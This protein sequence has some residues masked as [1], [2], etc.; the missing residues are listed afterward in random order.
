MQDWG[1][2]DEMYNT[3]TRP[4]NSE[5]QKKNNKKEGYQQPSCPLV[6]RPPWRCRLRRE[7]L[8]S[9]QAVGAHALAPK[10]GPSDN[11]QWNR[12]YIPTWR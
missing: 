9:Q 6:A 12:S 2:N 3:S 1:Q 4:N 7:A 5:E 11:R 8:K 10:M